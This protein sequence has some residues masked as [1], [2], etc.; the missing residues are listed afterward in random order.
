MEE[1]DFPSFQNQ[2]KTNMRLS[3]FPA[4]FCTQE[5][6]VDL[7]FVSQHALN[8]NRRLISGRHASQ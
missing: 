8:N 1:V 2:P 6:E 4:A 3:G 7:C 5:D